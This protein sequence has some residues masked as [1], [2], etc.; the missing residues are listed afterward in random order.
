MR[1][2]VDPTPVPTRRAAL[3]TR[4]RWAVRYIRRLRDG[5]PVTLKL[6]DLALN[7]LEELAEAR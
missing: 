5:E 6:I 3:S 2:I 7:W 1:L 4:A